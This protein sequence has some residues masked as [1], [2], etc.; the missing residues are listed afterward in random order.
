MLVAG[1]VP[2][3]RHP[4]KYVRTTLLFGAHLVSTFGPCCWSLG[5]YHKNDTFRVRADD[6]ALRSTLLVS[7]FGLI[8]SPPAGNTDHSAAE[9]PKPHP[10]DLFAPRSAGMLHGTFPRVASTSLKIG[11]RPV[12]FLRFGAVRHMHDAPRTSILEST[13]RITIDGDFA[14]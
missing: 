9:L 7:A 14:C 4:T 12:L 11:H 1:H 10:S 2:H 8:S 3:G 13:L 5:T 6:T